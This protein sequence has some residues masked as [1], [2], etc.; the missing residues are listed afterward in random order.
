MSPKHP[1]VV[2]PPSVT[3]FTTARPPMPLS[4]ALARRKETAVL[5]SALDLDDAG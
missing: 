2:L 1:P 5:V 3:T 4:A